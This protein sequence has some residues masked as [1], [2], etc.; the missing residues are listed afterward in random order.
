MKTGGQNCRGIEKSD[1]KEIVWDNKF[2]ESS[3]GT[4][5][6]AAPGPASAGSAARF[7]GASQVN[8]SLHWQTSF[9]QRQRNLDA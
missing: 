4:R 5:V 1:G 3:A 6:A 8:S 9:E 2:P 7:L